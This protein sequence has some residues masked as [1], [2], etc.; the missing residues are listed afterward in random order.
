VADKIT[1]S[2]IR[3]RSD[4][5]AVENGCRFD[6]ARAAHILGFFRD[7]L[8]FYEGDSAGKNFDPLPWQV[9]LLSRAF[10][11]VRHSV[12]WGRDVRRFRKVIVFAPKKNGK[13][14]IAAGV[15]LY[16]FLFDGE[17]GQKVFSCARD[18]RQAKIVHTHASMMTKKS[19]ALNAECKI[20]KSTGRISHA[21]SN[22]FYDILAGDNIPGQEGL[23][24]S[25]IIDEAHVVDDR[26]AKVLE[27]MGASRSEPMQFIISTAGDDPESWGRREYEYGKSVESGQILDDQVLFIAYEAPQDVSD[28]DIVNKPEIWQAANPSWGETIKEEEFRTSLARAKSKS[29][30]DWITFKRYRLNIWSTSVNPWLPMDRWSACRHE[31]TEDDLVGRRCFAG[32]DLSKTQDMSSLVLVFPDDDGE[33]GFAVLPYFWLPE[34]MATEKNHLVSFLE[35]AKCGYLELTPG[36]G[37]DYRYIKRRVIELS[38]KFAIEKV[39]YDR[40][41]ADQ[42]T[43][44][45]NEET[46]I[47]RVEFGQKIM[48]FAG[49][50][51]GFEGAV[52]AGKLRHNGHPIMT[53]Q[54]GHTQVKTDVNMNKRPVKPKPNDVRKIDGVVAAIMAFA[55]AEHSQP[56]YIP[57][58]LLDR[59]MMGAPA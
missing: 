4:D 26:L 8:K 59:D 34:E 51:A 37:I 38:Q 56:L 29:L 35:W 14:P 2:W 58:S 6:S 1:Q 22:S 47:E 15:G 13:S 33:Q 54:A 28:D 11:W 48:N 19:K 41:Y 46:G 50:T 3:N 17:Q 9:D 16:L 36:N 7:H 40:T 45:I 44:E 30:A 32:I 25:A 18:G 52:I 10:G 5:I 12:D 55:L 39:V 43:Q 23:N 27:Y 24:G 53:W 31:F 21:S 42:L 20:N 49:P 57:G